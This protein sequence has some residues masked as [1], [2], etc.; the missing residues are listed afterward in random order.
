MSKK[1]KK[2]VKIKIPKAKADA[3]KAG[4]KVVKAKTA[5]K[6]AKAAPKTKIKAKGGRV[7][8]TSLFSLANSL[9]PL[10]NIIAKGIEKAK[11][12]LRQPD[13]KDYVAWATPGTTGTPK[14][15]GGLWVHGGVLCVQ[16]RW[17]SPE[18]LEKAQ[19]MGFTVYGTLKADLK[20]NRIHVGTESQAKQ[21]VELL[22]MQAKAIAEGRTG[23]SNLNK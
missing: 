4:K 1:T 21:V 3:L 13:H 8:F 15:I 18:V 17:M 14:R 11:G 20:C 16:I 9:V 7:P 10:A 12:V 6:T 22:E 5:A 2:A 19:K 23:S